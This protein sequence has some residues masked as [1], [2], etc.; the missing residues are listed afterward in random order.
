MN[1]GLTLVISLVIVGVTFL[2]LYLMWKKDEKEFTPDNVTDLKYDPETEIMSFNGGATGKHY[3][4]RGRCTVW[5]SMSGKRLDTMMESKLSDIWS[6]WKYS[7]K[8]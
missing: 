3:K 4:V 5:H 7:E 1:Y 2:G 8:D 6:Y